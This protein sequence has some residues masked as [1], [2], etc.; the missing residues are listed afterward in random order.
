MLP[1][2]FQRL[3][4]RPRRHAQEQACSQPP[5]LGGPPRGPRWRPRPP[6][7]GRARALR[8]RGPQSRLASTGRGPTDV[9]IALIPYPL[10]PPA[11]RACAQRRAPPSHRRDMLADAAVEAFDERR[12]ALPATGRP[13]LRNRRP[14]A[15]PAPLVPPSPAPPAYRLEPLG[16][17][18]R[19]PGHP[20]GR[21][22]GPG[23]LPTGA[24]HPLALGR[25]P[26]GPVCLEAV[27]QTQGDA[28]RG[29]PLAHL[30]AHTLGQGH[31]A[32]PDVH[33]QPHFARES[34]RRPPQGGERER[35]SL[36]PSSLPGPSLSAL[37]TA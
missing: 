1:R 28:V 18:P 31:A 5:D 22:R 7:R 8:R 9:L 36:A 17:E 32:F 23:G 24:R 4:L 19:W 35:R 37:S 6:A 15:A 30:M 14:R 10:L 33:R 27:A 21:G 16:L 26:G 29:Q 11:V 34:E 20:A 25:A 12:S 2:R 3:G 13:P